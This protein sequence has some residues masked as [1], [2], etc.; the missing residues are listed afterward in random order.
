MAYMDN[1]M[2]QL[3][4][5]QVDIFGTTETNI[6]WNNELRDEARSQCQQH[7]KTVIMSTS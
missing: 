4:T 7:Y 5:L 6:N 2:L 1:I 3:K